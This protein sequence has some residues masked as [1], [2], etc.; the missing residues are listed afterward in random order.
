MKFRHEARELTKIE[1]PN[2]ASNFARIDRSKAPEM[3]K[4]WESYEKRPQMSLDFL[5]VKLKKRLMPFQT[6]GIQY[7]IEKNGW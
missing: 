5:P 2:A 7:A 6:D 3:K 1:F 4:E